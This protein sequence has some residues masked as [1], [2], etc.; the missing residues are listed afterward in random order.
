M[1]MAFSVMLSG[2]EKQESDGSGYNFDCA[3]V[4]HPESLDPQ[5]AQDECSLTVIENLYTGLLDLDENGNIKNAAAESYTVSDDGLTYNFKLRNNC[6][7][8]YDENGDEEV[9]DSECKNVTAYDFEFAFRRI[10]NSETCSPHREKYLCIKN[11]QSIINGNTDYTQIGVK[12]I[13]DTELVFELEYPS[14]E[15]LNS[16][17]LS[18]AMPCNEEFFYDTKGRYGLDDK[19]VMSDGAFFVR[20]WFYDP[21]GNDNFIYMQR[22]LANSKYDRIYPTALNF[23]M[24]DSF[25]EAKEAFDKGE[26]DVIMSFICSESTKD[27]YDIKAY[28]NCTVGILTN[29]ENPRYSNINIKKAFAFGIDKDSFDEQLSDDISKAYG[30]IPPDVYINGKSYRELTEDNVPYYSINDDMPVEYNP[31]LAVSYYHKGMEQMNLQS[32]ENTK[33]LV[34]ENLMD[35]EYLHL[36]TQSWQ[37][38]FGFYIGIE[39]VPEDEFYNRIEEGDYALAIYPLTGNYHSPVSFIEK[40]AL[41]EH[42]IG[43]YN[44]QLKSTYDSLLKVGDYNNHLDEIV[45]AEKMILNS[46]DFI[47]VFYKTEY[48]ILGKGNKDI[49]YNPFTKQINFRYAKYFD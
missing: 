27:E 49:N 1:I 47:P 20:Q 48:E 40:F 33:L 23:Y 29:P 39:E 13:S 15:F 44:P 14:A 22:N 41:S 37:T 26:S 31:D 5:F 6:F 42:P 9:S 34:P 16:L 3:I 21:Y 45:E 25:K 36:V 4:G 18:P 32:L 43:V 11:A 28:K 2:C 46:F 17:T 8:F 35:T 19:S 7:W 12:A 10:F 38:L 30:I 24:K